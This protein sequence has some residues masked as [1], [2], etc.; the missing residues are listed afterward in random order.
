[1]KQKFNLN[2]I[3]LMSSLCLVNNSYGQDEDELGGDDCFEC[4][5]DPNWCID[6]PEVCVGNCDDDDAC[7]ECSCDSFWCEDPIEEDDY[8]CFEC[9]CDDTFCEDPIEDQEGDDD[10]AEKTAG[11]TKPEGKVIAIFYQGGPF[12]GGNDVDPSEAGGAGRRFNDLKSTVGETGK[13]FKGE[14]IASGLTASSGV[15]NGAEFIRNNYQPG[16]QIVIYG[17]SWGGDLAVELLSELNSGG[18]FNTS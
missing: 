3:F 5:C 11:G 15:E 17:Y 18:E 14:V 10:C 4:S 1:M 8:D 9:Y 16:D 12:G 7:F 6:L 2:K 13:E